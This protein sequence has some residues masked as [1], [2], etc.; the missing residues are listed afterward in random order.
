MDEP[1]QWSRHAQRK[2][3][4]FRLGAGAA[5]LIIM[6]SLAASVV[7]T[8]FGTDTAHSSRLPT[9]SASAAPKRIYVHVLGEVSSPDLYE[10]DSGSRV[11]DA[12]SAAGGLTDDADP[13]AVNL[14]RVLNDGEQIDV[15]AVGD[16][17]EE[18]PD[19]DKVSINQAS[20][21]D[22]EALPQIGPSLAQ[23]IIA[24]R[25]ENGPFQTI[26]DLKNVS[27]IGDKTLAMFRDLISL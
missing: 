19:G 7:V 6:V 26:D 24:W 8:M 25:D 23:R 17:K 12:I 21:D 4:R 18:T 5:V 2:H 22:L 16:E 20:A 1:A 13:A 14:A 9:P 3:P 10:L 15:P 11:A 27:G